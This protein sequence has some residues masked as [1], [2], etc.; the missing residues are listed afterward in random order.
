MNKSRLF[1]IYSTRCVKCGAPGC[2]ELPAQDVHGES[3]SR[4]T[5][6]ERWVLWSDENDEVCG[7]VCG[8]CK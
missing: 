3:W 5:L 8:Y 4:A 2:I 7:A 1:K 6:P